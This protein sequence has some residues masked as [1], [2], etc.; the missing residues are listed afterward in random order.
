MNGKKMAAALA[1]ILVMGLCEPVGYA[2]KTV[3]D[4]KNHE[5]NIAAT[6]QMVKQ[7]EQQAQ[8]LKNEMA[9]L[10]KINPK[11]MK[12]TID[13]IKGVVNTVNELRNS[14]QAIGTSYHDLMADFDALRP[15]YE[16]WNGASALEYAKQVDKFRQVM[17]RS[18]EQAMKSQGINAPEEQA[19]TTEV[20][21]ELVT[22]SQNASGAMG[23]L[24]TLNQIAGVT[25]SELQKMQVVMTDSLRTQNL[26][27]QRK[28]DAEKQAKKIS[29]DFIA[30][31]KELTDV[32]FTEGNKQLGNY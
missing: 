7:V 32:R 20:L 25:V 26:Y 31:S 19:K 21:D 12:A 18:I 6:A 13:Q 10:E 8:Q 22:A 4:P 24:Q 16:S 5:E 30:S 2:W 1:G 17:E 3:Y 29:A 28:L 9:N 11:N 27:Y 15:D 23:A 14:V